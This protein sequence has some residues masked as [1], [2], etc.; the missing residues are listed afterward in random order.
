MKHS[1]QLT[2]ISRFIL[3]VFISSVARFQLDAQTDSSLA[4]FPLQLNNLWQ[5]HFHYYD[6]C[7]NYN[8][9]SY[10][11]VRV[12]GDTV[13]PNGLTYKVLETSLP[14]LLSTRYLRVDSATANVY[15]FSGDTSIADYLVDSLRATVGD[16]FRSTHATR[17]DLF[18]T[19]PMT[20]PQSWECV[21][22]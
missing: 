18:D 16:T 6:C 10:F 14:Q 2:M 11:T 9:S 5:Y 8:I 7:C 1:L 15:E 3:L 20:L 21:R 19:L 12:A 17:G 4:F 13:L 22:S